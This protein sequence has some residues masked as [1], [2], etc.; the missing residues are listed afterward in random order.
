MNRKDLNVLF[1]PEF[2]GILRE[3]IYRDK[4]SSQQKDG[5]V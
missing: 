4:I 5:T 1:R 2:T 3:K